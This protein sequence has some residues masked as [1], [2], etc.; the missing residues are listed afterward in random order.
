MRYLNYWSIRRCFRRHQPRTYTACQRIYATEDAAYL[1]LKSMRNR[2]EISK[3][4]LETFPLRCQSCDKPSATKSWE[5]QRKL[6]IMTSYHR[7]NV[8]IRSSTM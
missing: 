6:P 3:S 5:T 2:F 4:I 1:S 8:L 7:P